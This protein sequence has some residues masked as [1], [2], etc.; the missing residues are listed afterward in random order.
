[1]SKKKDNCQSD[2]DCIETET[3]YMGFC[4]DLC[5]LPGVCAPNANCQ[6]KMHRPICMCPK[7]HGGNPAINCTS[8]NLCK[9]NFLIHL[10][11]NSNL[12]STNQ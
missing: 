10:K 12:K 3:C 2:N 1:M 11:S 4:D 9:N 7:G 8:T 6:V 5:Q